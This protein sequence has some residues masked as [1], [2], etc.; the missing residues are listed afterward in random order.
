M[1]KR[2]VAVVVHEDRHADVEVTVFATPREAIAYAMKTAR[3][4]D[5]HGDLVESLTPSMAARDWL[6]HASYG[7]SNYIRV[8]LCDVVESEGST[9]G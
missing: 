4:M 9:R 5:R 2:T 8:Q 7:E 1:A 3:E 6:Y